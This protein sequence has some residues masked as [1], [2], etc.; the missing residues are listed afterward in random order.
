MYL[1]ISFY[2]YL[3]SFPSP[4]PIPSKSNS[5]TDGERR[6][7]PKKRL[8]FFFSTMLS[9][10]SGSSRKQDHFIFAIRDGHFSELMMVNSKKRFNSK[11]QGI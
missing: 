1:Q 5:H 10:I 7:F 4:K 8:N 9:Y 2:W 11:G 3:Y 6:N